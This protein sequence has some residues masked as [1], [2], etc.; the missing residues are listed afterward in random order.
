M[1]VDQALALSAERL[2]TV[3]RRAGR[4]AQA[5]ADIVAE[6]IPLADI[7]CRP[8]GQFAVGRYACAMQISPRKRDRAWS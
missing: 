2:T 6:D 3:W 5:D 7:A 8:V 4:A 1:P